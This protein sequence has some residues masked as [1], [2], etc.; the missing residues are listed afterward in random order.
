MYPI[1]LVSYHIACTQYDDAAQ[2]EM[3]KAFLQYVLSEEGQQAAAEAAGS[4]PISDAIREPALQA[5]D[6]IQTG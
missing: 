4:A 3:V 6:A 1:V 2:A 5:V